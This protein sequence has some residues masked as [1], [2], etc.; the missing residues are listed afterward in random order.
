[1]RLCGQMDVVEG[2][3]VTL[4]QCVLCMGKGFKVRNE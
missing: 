3:P 4:E 2:Y 1:M